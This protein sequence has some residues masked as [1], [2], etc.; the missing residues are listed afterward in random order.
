MPDAGLLEVDGIDGQ[1]AP[2]AARQRIGAALQS[3]ALPEKMTPREALTVFGAFY[4]RRIP[5]VALLERS[6]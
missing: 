6:R 3:T 5:A 1:E 4:P 2:A